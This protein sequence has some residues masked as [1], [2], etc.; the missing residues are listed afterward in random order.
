MN[1]NLIK[2]K[3]AKNDEFYTRTIDIENEVYYYWHHLKDKVIYCNCDNY[4]T[5]MFFRYFSL[6]FEHLGLKQLIATSYNED[7][8]GVYAEYNGDQ[9]GNR[10][11][12]E[13]EITVR[14]L[15]GDGDFRSPECQEI[16]AKADIVITNPPFS[17][18]RDFIHLLECYEKQYLII[19]NMNAI[20]YKEVFPLIKE[21]KLWLGNTFPKVFIQQDD[22]EKKFGNICWFTNLDIEKRHENLILIEDYDEEKYPKYDNYD[23]INVDKTNDIPCDYDGAIGVPITFLTKYNPEQF[24]ILGLANSAR[25]IDYECF[26]IIDGRK[27][28][29]RIIIKRR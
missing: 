29:N 9:N 26:T 6:Q 25:W 22:S 4:K 18:F 16:L 11:P 17:L 24:E 2:A 20:T 3:K 5:S 15:D 28:Y 19:G 12:D 10:M 1:K 13:D 27:I 8:K 7:G 21:D 14:E 23:A